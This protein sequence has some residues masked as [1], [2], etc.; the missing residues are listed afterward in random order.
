VQVAD[1]ITVKAPH[2][3]RPMAVMFSTED[4]ALTLDHPDQRAMFEIPGRTGGNA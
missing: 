1:T 2:G 3:E 4:G